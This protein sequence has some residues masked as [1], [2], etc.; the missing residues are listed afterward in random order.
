MT[1]DAKEPRGLAELSLAAHHEEAREWDASLRVD[2]AQLE[3]RGKAPRELGLEECPDCGWWRDP[4]P[5]SARS[6]L[7]AFRTYLR[8]A[9]A[10]CLCTASRCFWCHEPLNPDVPTPEYYDPARRGIVH[11][12]GL[13]GGLSHATRCE[14]R[15]GS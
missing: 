2:E 15:R 4:I 14:A 7:E 6:T 5:G 9:R 11:S 1:T 3:A 12:G 8:V 10:R 13:T